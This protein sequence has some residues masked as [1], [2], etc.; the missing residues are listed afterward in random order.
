LLT[1]E[2]RHDSRLLH[3]EMRFRLGLVRSSLALIQRYAHRCH[4]FDAARLREMC[5]GDS[6]RAERLLTFDFARYLF[7]A[8]L[9]PLVDAPIAGL[10]PDLLGPGPTARLYVEAKQYSGRSPAARLRKAYLQVWST[11]ARLRNAAPIREAFMVVFR[12]AGPLVVL[13]DMIPHEGL[14]LYSVVVDLS[15]EGGSKEK[16]PPIVLT[17][18]ELRPRV[19]ST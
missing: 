13:P 16:R 18:D 2:V 9:E 4:S 6:K 5:K 10:R 14:R 3:E 12:T 7:D 1:E 17:A 19:A 11:W 15:R 8:G